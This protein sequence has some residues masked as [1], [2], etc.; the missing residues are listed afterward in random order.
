MFGINSLVEIFPMLFMS[1]L[2]F[3]AKRRFSRK[4]NLAVYFFGGL[5]YAG[6]LY[7]ICS[8]IQDCAKYETLFNVAYSLAAVLVCRLLFDSDIIKLL[9]SMILTISCAVSFNFFSQFIIALFRPDIFH[10]PAYSPVF[11][12]EY[13]VTLIVLMAAVLPFFYRF[14]KNT[15]SE[16]F[17]E[18]SMKIVASLCITPALVYVLFCVYYVA[19]SEADNISAVSIAFTRMAILLV[20]LVSYYINL[21]IMLNTARRL[22]EEKN[23]AFENS[24]LGHYNQLKTELMKTIAHQAR[25]ELAILSSYA[26]LVAMQLREKGLESQISENLDQVV[27]ESKR[28]ANLI[29]SISMAALVGKNDSEYISVDMG[30]LVKKTTRLFGHMFEAQGA[31]LEIDVGEGIFPIFGCPEKLT[32]LLTTLLDNAHKYATDPSLVPGENKVT[33]GVR[34][35]NGEIITSV[36]DRGPGIRDE[37]LENIFERGVTGRPGGSGIGLAVCKEIVEAHKGDIAIKSETAKGTTVTFKI[38][39]ILSEAK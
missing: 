24:V 7:A 34:H 20:G 26:S 17:G 25:T 11:T 39:A 2:P 5:V 38:P 3:R 21:R 33:V 13:T 31:S 1:C 10:P 12:V 29:D 18:L 28:L 14:F 8:S 16:A 4:T 37:I 9:Y 30:G 15:L 27:F 22:R 35:E 36:S 6:G 19:I 32:D 23:L